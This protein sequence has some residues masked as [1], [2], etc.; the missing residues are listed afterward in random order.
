[1]SL[2]RKVPLVTGEIYHIF[3]R[4]IDGRVT[5]FDTNEYLR[6][7]QVMKYYQFSSPSLKLSKFLRV[8]DSK[9]QKLQE[10]YQGEKL[11]LIISYCFMPN[12]FHLLL[13][14]EADRGISKFLSQFQ[15][16]YTRYFN[17]KNKRVGQLFL[18]NFKNV[19]VEGEEQFLHLS[20]YIHLNPYSSSVV[21]SLDNLYK[22]EWSSLSEYLGESD[23]F[24]CDKELILS[25][26]KTKESYRDFVSNQAKYQKELKTIENL[27][28]DECP[29]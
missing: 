18:D 23:D 28:I 22:Y 27:L 12:H 16:S 2:P 29:T 4:G 6:A 11:V 21:S 3:N 19:L 24:I 20:R 14:Q 8:S 1:M 10:T 9:R 25:Q 15:N 26:F 5:F 17:T 13:R 7:Y